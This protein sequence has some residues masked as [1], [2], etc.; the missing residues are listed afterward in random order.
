MSTPISRT[1]VLK[2]DV[3]IDRD[4]AARLGHSAATQSTPPSTT[5]SAS[6]RSPPSTEQLNQYH[7][8]MEVDRSYQQT[9]M[10]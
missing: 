1:A 4:T 6:A 2:P 7:V 10:L 9:P 3:V 8:V 5:P